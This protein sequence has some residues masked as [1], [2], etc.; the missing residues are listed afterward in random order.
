MSGVQKHLKVMIGL[1]VPLL[2]AQ[3]STKLY[4][5][6]GIKRCVYGMLNVGNVCKLY[7]TVELISGLQ[8]SVLMEERLFLLVATLSMI[9]LRIVSCAY[10]IFKQGTVAK[11]SGDIKARSMMYPSVQMVAFYYQRVIC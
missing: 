8:N 9:I 2:S 11:L 1:S 5:E 10:G 4:R 6:A 3:I 7:R